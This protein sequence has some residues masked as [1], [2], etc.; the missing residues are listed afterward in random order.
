MEYDLSKSLPVTASFDS[1]IRVWN[2]GSGECVGIFRGHTRGIR[3]LSLQGGELVS[4]SSD[5]DLKFWDLTSMTCTRT[6]LITA[7]ADGTAKIW[8]ADGRLLLTLQHQTA[9]LCVAGDLRRVVTGCEDAKVWVW[10]A[11]SGN[12]LCR[13]G[14]ADEG[15]SVYSCALDGENVFCGGDGGV[16]KCIHIVSAIA[17]NPTSSTP[18][19]P[20]S[21]SDIQLDPKNLYIKN[22]EPHI[23]DNLLSDMFSSFGRITSARIMRDDTTGRSKGFGF[24]SFESS[25]QA[26]RALRE[27]NGKRSYRAKRIGEGLG[28]RVFDGDFEGWEEEGSDGVGEWDEDEQQDLEELSNLRILSGEID[29]ALGVLRR[30]VE[31]LVRRRRKRRR[32]AKDVGVGSHDRKQQ[33]MH[34]E[35]SNTCTPPTPITTP[36]HTTT[37]SLP[38]VRSSENSPKHS[39]SPAHSSNGTSR[40]AL[41]HGGIL[42][43]EFGQE[44]RVEDRKRLE[45]ILMMKIAREKAILERADAASRPVPTVSGGRGVVV[46]RMAGGSDGV[47]AGGGVGRVGAYTTAAARTEEEKRQARRLSARS[48]RRVVGA[49]AEDPTQESGH[50]S[51][52]HSS[53]SPT[54]SSPAYSPPTSHPNSPSASPPYSPTQS[55]YS[56]AYSSPSSPQMPP[57]HER[58]AKTTHTTGASTEANDNGGRDCAVPGGVGGMT[59]V[60]AV[61]RR[62]SIGSAGSL[63]VL[64]GKESR[65]EALQDRMRV[66][67]EGGGSQSGS[68]VGDVDDPAGLGVV[69]P[70]YGGIDGVG[71]GGRYGFPWVE[72]RQQGVLREWDGGGGEWADGEGGRYGYGG[73]Y[74]GFGGFFG[75]GDGWS[76]GSGGLGYGGSGAGDQG[77]EYIP[78]AGGGRD[79][80]VGG[81]VGRGGSG[82]GMRPARQKRGFDGILLR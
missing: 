2:T 11:L 24:I 19:T 53:P 12:L 68:N 73:V 62:L 54:P 22:L 20:S 69:P 17:N 66:L 47:A 23:D 9:V 65:L 16:V 40:S 57:R 6:K 1:S 71:G 60:G 31:G 32:R 49:L 34:G 18:S 7:S 8:D 21:R 44:R 58:P 81:L 59:G 56:P 78:R 72:Q 5:G 29:E 14:G 46:E 38:H 50:T 25:D 37:F 13:V 79:G 27:M 26:A 61:G 64:E 52:Q 77:E 75:E 80:S 10:D 41:L 30:G 36:A 4:A 42:T 15:G 35:T 74:G 33:Q 67:K 70:G 45:E 39:K 51:N 82:R 63:R 55:A 43:T 3:G 28:V 48:V 76:G